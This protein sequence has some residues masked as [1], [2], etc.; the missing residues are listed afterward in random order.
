MVAAENFW[1]DIVGQ[2]GG[3]HVRVDSIISDPNTDPHEYESSA[4]DAVAIAGA[5]LVVVNGLGYDSFMDGLLKA[6]PNPS[7]TVLSVQQVLGI[8]GA[9]ANPHVWYDTAQLPRVASAIAAALSRLDAA[10]AAAF[11]ANA[12]AFDASLAPITAVIDTI[13]AKYAGT[14]IAYTERVPGYLVRAAGLVLGVPAGFAQ[15]VESGTD[16]SPK[17]TAAFDDAIRTRA[18]KVLL[19]NG[20]VTDPQTDQIKALAARD[21]IPLVAVTETLPATDKDFQAWQLRQARE[22]LAALGG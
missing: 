10:N 21:G 14:K 9:D 15:A 3:D 13:R 18:V 4:K 12:R 5:R 6:S 17:D 22:L 8:T 1:G 11:A 2:I 7:R 19:Y 16:P 20:Q